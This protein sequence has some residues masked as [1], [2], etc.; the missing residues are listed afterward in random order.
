MSL[1]SFSVHFQRSQVFP[2]RQGW[3][4][5]DPLAE[6]YIRTWCRTGFGPE[7]DL[8]RRNENGENAA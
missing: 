5:S 6:S 1:M 4:G 2:E 3:L 8:P 7:L